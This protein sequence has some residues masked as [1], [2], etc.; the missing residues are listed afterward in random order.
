M[1]MQ[2]RIAVVIVAAIVMMHMH[3]LEQDGLLWS[4]LIPAH[5]HL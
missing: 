3:G 1:M 5:P 4:L 2:V